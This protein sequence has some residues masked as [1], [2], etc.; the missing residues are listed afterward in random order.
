MKRDELKSYADVTH[1]IQSGHLEDL[2]AMYVFLPPGYRNSQE[3]YPVLYINDG[4]DIKQLKLRETLKRLYEHQLIEGLIVVAIPAVQR[5]QEYGTAGI[6][7]YVHRGSL[8]EQYT[9][10]LIN[11]AIPLINAS[12]RTSRQTS[13]T[14]IMGFSLSALSALDIAWRFPYHFGKVGVFSG[15][16]WWRQKSLTENYS[17]NDRIMHKLI[18][19]GEKR[20]GLKFW[21]EAGTEDEKSDRNNNG[22]IDAIDDTL[23][24]MKELEKKGYQREVDFTYQQVEGGQHNYHTWSKVFPEF[25]I[26]A[27]GADIS[28]V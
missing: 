26:W 1:Y 2:R 15:S 25:L 3:R 17:D 27:Y 7:D 11:E 28:V 6:P 20:E 18:R 5:L 23:D 21:F 12:Y 14:S 8:A 9:R 13:D 10:F 22:I 4:Q 16:L 24:L 19:E